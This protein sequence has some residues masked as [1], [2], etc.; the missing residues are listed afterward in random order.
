MPNSTRSELKRE[1]E[2]ANG[3]LDW[4]KH[5]LATIHQI[6]FNAVN[7]NVELD[8]DIPTAYAEIISDILCLWEATDELT[9]ATNLLGSKI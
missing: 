5:H 8:A 9:K 7:N 2:R 4:Y 1:I 6:F 3:N